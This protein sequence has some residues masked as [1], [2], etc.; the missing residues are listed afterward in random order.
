MGD[1]APVLSRRGRHRVLAVLC[2]TEIIGYGVL[3]YAFPVLAVGMAADTGWSTAQLTAAFSLALVVSAL[4]GVP[5]G[6]VLDRTGPRAV[7]TAGSVLAVPAVLAV[8]TATSLPW[9]VASWVLVG[10]AM[11]GV[12]YPPAFAALTRWWGPRSGVA[13]TALTLAAGLASTIFAPLTAALAGS[14]GWRGAYLVLT[15][16]LAVTVPLHALGLRGSWPP[17]EAEGREAVVDPGRVARSRPFV[18]LTAAITLGTFAAYAVIVNQVP[19]LVERGLSPG[20]AAWALGLGGLGQVAGRFAWGPLAARTGVRARTVGVLAVSAAATALLAVLPGPGALLVA[21]A[22][23]A[24]AAR[25]ALTLLQATAVS[26]RWGAAH[27]GRLSG[28]VAAPTT[29]LTALGPWAGAAG[30]ERLGGYPEVFGLLAA[31]AAAAA[32]LALGSVPRT[33]DGP[34]APLRSGSRPAPDR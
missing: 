28:L 27:Y 19:L 16:V 11:A 26:D 17:V 23:L 5:V 9:F 30:A 31:V 24:G 4:V 2:V 21:G 13:L 8:A 18:L 33:V 14:L 20:A 6:R 15:A 3:F 10:V 12:F 34:A 1:P 22:V 29:L 25:G 7:M 32:A